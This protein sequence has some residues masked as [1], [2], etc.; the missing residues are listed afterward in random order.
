MRESVIDDPASGCSGKW[1]KIT[2]NPYLHKSFVLQSDE[3]IRVPEA[4]IVE[5]R[6]D[7]VWAFSPTKIKIDE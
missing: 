1:E 3:S 6:R 7:G 5:I 4:W 2:Y